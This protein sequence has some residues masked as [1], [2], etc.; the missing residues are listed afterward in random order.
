MG[1]RNYP[2]NRPFGKLMGGFGPFFKE[3][4]YAF[5]A[6]LFPKKVKN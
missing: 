4:L 6:H 3:V 5:L 1:S 2:G